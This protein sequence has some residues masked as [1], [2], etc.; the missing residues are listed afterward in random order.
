M[1]VAKQEERVKKY[2]KE[3]MSRSE[4]FKQPLERS[5]STTRIPTPASS[6]R[7]LRTQLD[8]NSS[9]RRSSR[10]R[11]KCVKQILPPPMAV[12]SDFE[13]ESEEKEKKKSSRRKLY[14]HTDEEVHL[15]G[16]NVQEPESTVHSP[17]TMIKHN[18]RTRRML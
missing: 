6:R 14:N 12:S 7:P 18:L 1:K 16:I 4:T 10:Q 13:E 8:E 9:S 11:K 15:T 2:Q 5:A 3:L 17:N